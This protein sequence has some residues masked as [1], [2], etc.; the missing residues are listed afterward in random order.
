[1]EKKL[2]SALLALKYEAPR[3]IEEGIL[4]KVSM[5]EK[6]ASYV[7]LG[8]FSL[9]GVLSVVSIVPVWKMLLIDLS[10][11]GLY[12]YFSLIFSDGGMI[13]SNWREFISTIAEA[14]PATSLIFLFASFFTLA[15]SVKFIIDQIIIKNMSQNFR[16]NFGR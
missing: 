4:R 11:S 10:Q 2:K 8:S 1:M 3:G 5:Y 12:Q 16:F 6:R 9:L 13:L 14:V 15:L 7:K